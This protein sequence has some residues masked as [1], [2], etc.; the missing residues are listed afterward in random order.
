MYTLEVEECV[1]LCVCV[2]ES[3]GSRWVALWGSWA[4]T[5]R[6]LWSSGDQSIKASFLRSVLSHLSIGQAESRVPAGRCVFSF[7]H[8]FCV[9]NTSVIGVESLSGGP[10]LRSPGRFLCC[11]ATSVIYRGA[12]LGWD[13]YL[14]TLHKRFCGGSSSNGLVKE[15]SKSLGKQHTE[16]NVSTAECDISPLAHFYK[17]MLIFFSFCFYLHGASLK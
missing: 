15:L 2:C 6:E 7:I 14:E 12:R 5:K 3:A 10:L 8:S 16:S 11:C 9:Y 1:C 4:G 13:R 17:C